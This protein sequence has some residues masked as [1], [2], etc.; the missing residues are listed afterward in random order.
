VLIVTFDQK[1]WMV[2]GPGMPTHRHPS[3]K[4]AADEAERLAKLH[5]GQSFTVLEAIATAQARG[6]AWCRHDISESCL[7]EEP[8]F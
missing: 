3:L 5:P 6:I 8:P 2:L 4:S 1:Y 7:Q